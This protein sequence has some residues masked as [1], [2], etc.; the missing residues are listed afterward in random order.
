MLSL[1]VT[2]VVAPAALADDRSVAAG[3][4]LYLQNCASC[5][6]ASGEGAPNWSKPDAN[7]ELPPPPHDASGHTWRHSDADLQAMIEKGWRDPFNK[8]TRLTM[9]AFA[10][11]LSRAEIADVIGYLK[12]LW[13]PEERQYQSELN[14]SAN[15]NPARQ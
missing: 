9:P 10:S 5:H 12:T 6:G 1:L 7:G 11:V 3:R 13:T 15:T 8:T 14:R 2:L 4:S